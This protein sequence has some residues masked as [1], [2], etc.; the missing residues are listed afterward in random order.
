[1]L[2]FLTLISFHYFALAENL[3]NTFLRLSYNEGLVNNQATCIYKDSRGF[4][5]FGTSSG[6]SRYDGQNFK[7]YTHQ[8]KDTFSIQDNYIQEI[9]EDQNQDLW[10]KLRWNYAIFDFDQ[11]KFFYA[12]HRLQE[13]GIGL[14]VDRI[15]FDLHKQMWVKTSQTNNYQRYDA[16]KKQL[17]DVFGESSYKEAIPIDFIQFENQYYCLYEDGTIE[18]FRADDLRLLYRSEYLK[19]KIK[20]KYAA[21][22]IYVDRKGKLYVYG[23]SNGVYCYYPLDKQ[24]IHLGAEANPYSISSDLVSGVLQDDKGRIWISTDHGGVNI[25]SENLEKLET[26]YHQPENRKSLSQ[27]S[28]TTMMKDD[29]GIIWLATYKNGISYYHDAFF[30]FEHFENIITSPNP[31]PFNDV[32]CFAEDKAGNLWIGT[33][34]GGLLYYDR[35]KEQYTIYKN[36]PEDAHSLSNNVVVNLLLDQEGQLWVGTYTGGLNRF[37]GKKF[38]RYILKDEMLADYFVNSIWCLA[39]LNER[40]IWLGTLGAG[41]LVLDKKTGQFSK[42]ENTGNMTLPNDFVNHIHVLK[43]GNLL[44]ATALG[45]VFYDV[46]KK[47]YSNNLYHEGNEK[48][49]ISNDNVND[50]YEDSRGLLWIASREG[51]TMIDPVVGKSFLL[52][53]EH[54]LPQDIMNCILEDNLG[55]LWV[56]KSSGISKLQ[57]IRQQGEWQFDVQSF[58]QEDGLQGLEYNVNAKIRT[59][60]GELAF[61]GFNG[62]NLFNPEKIEYKQFESKVIFNDL[63]LNNRSVKIGEQ[64]SGQVLL[65]KSIE[66]ADQITLPPSVNVF[67]IDFTA[68]DYS[69]GSTKYAYK[70]EGFEENWTQTAE[71]YSKVTYTNLYPGTYLLKVKATRSSEFPESFASI[72]IVVE[73][74][75]YLSP[76]AFLIYFF[77]LFLSIFASTYFFVRRQRS[78][79]LAEQRKIEREQN[80]RLDEIKLKFLTNISHEF[81]TPLTLILTPLEKLIKLNQGNN[82]YGSLKVIERNAQELL[83]LVNQLLD[84]RKLDL[85]GLEFHPSYGDIVPFVRQI[86][87]MFNDSFQ[88]SE[89]N[90]EFHT[91]KDAVSFLFDKDKVRKILMNLLGNAIKFTPARGRVTVRINIA[92]GYFLK[93]DGLELT[94]CDSGVGIAA[95]DLEH[96]FTRFYQSSNVEDLGKG[97][98]G[99]GLNLVKEMVTLHQGQI[100]VDSTPGAGTE[101]RVYLPLIYH[102]SSDM[103]VQQ[104]EG[105][106]TLLPEEKQGNQPTILLVED[107]PDFRHFMKEALE[108]KYQVVEAEEGAKGLELTRKLLPDLVI[109]D[110]MMPVMDGL[111]LCKTIKSEA[112]ISHI[113]VILLT[114]RT[115]DEDK[116]K[117][118]EIGADD[119]ITK[120]FKMDLLLKRIDQ[121]MARREK[122]QKNFQKKLEVSPA[123]VEIT[124]LDEKLINNALKIVEENIGK[125]DFSV[126]EMSKELGMS[127]VHLYKKLTAITGKS[128]VEFIRIIRLKRGKKLLEKSQM[129][130]SEVAYEVGFNSP[131]YFSKYFAKEY[132]MLPSKYLKKIQENNDFHIEL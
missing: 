12:P 32:N 61:G 124:P 9:V 66:V 17:V 80:Q 109:S 59:N 97:G 115:A 19:S 77:L 51:L 100:E 122:A 63:Q 5:W 58:G 33:N 103:E 84:F 67:S 10:I 40:Y 7:N 117:G 95:D 70:L 16:D 89:I 73:P 78:K 71:Q 24:W 38:H 123:E 129:T 41:I 46:D 96:I 23:D 34:G 132:G 36:D 43:D 49:K 56:S 29:E 65:E 87:E 107:N 113:P 125:S 6:L 1:M 120:P 116:I 99:I 26:F 101:F 105:E 68:V 83:Y 119:Y 90:F 52:D 25:F 104:V 72:K 82:Q 3:S 88:R 121:Y 69:T 4:L 30:K 126:E 98:S 47:S 74:P 2:T 48:F 81:R 53:K 112:E 37:D 35:K 55:N 127:R 118:Y 8:E 94:V 50:V 128:P 79:L 21:G 15:Y 62:F 131:R 110:V 18:V 28:I 54:D 14:D 111:E 42:P 76:A 102:Q 85:H 39:E 57:I 106:N 11:G 31:L 75:F 22:G 130:V 20:S 86:C 108:G 91:D 64:I 114:A 44:I 60:A 13:M 27:N 92:L 45:I 93:G